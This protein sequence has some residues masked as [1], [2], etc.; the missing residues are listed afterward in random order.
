VTEVDEVVRAL[1]DGKLAVV[2]TDTVYGLVCNASSREPAAD[3][4]RLKG[5]SAIQPTA[6][7]VAAVDELPRFLPELDARVLAIAG[8][9]LPGPYT[10]VVPNPA[11]RFEWLTEGRPGTL[12]LRIPALSGVAAAVLEGVG[13]AVATSANLPGGSDP[14]TLSEV[15]PEIL[16]GVAAVVD[17]GELPGT[18]STVID[19]TAAEP[20]I[21]RAGAG[22]PDTVLARIAAV[23]S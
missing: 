12:G 3:L 22:D 8:A 21:L 5:R 23:V 14:R 19:V 18:P 13:V 7:L 2:P 16:A 4:Y 20:V 11:G 6:V 9:L 1:R 17:G 15:P 10:L